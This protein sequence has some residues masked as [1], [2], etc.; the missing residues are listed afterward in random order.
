MTERMTAALADCAKHHV[1]MP[2][3]HMKRSVASWECPYCKIAELEAQ[4]KT[5][6]WTKSVMGNYGEYDNWATECGEDFAIEEEWHEKPTKFCANCG[7]K[8]VETQGD[9]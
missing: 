6:K 5:C 7:G 9:T 8:T 4:Q 1:A 3:D 2:L